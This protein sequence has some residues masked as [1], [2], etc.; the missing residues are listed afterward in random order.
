MQ[1]ALDMSRKT[2]EAAMTPLNK[3]F[4]LSSEA[5]LDEE[6]LQSVLA[7]GHSRIPVYERRNRCT[8]A[9]CV[10]VC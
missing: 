8:A 3:V 5:V 7:S 4:M 2:A 10:D 6:T 9:V 1:G